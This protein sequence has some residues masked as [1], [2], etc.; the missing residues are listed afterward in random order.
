MTITT[1]ISAM[2]LAKIAEGADPIEAM[3]EVCG[4]DKVDAMISGLYDSLRAKVDQ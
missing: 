3:K 2:I 1:K 4:A